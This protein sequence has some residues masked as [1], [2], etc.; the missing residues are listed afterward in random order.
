MEGK[1]KQA[2][3][4][5]FLKDLFY[6]CSGFDVLN[7]RADKEILKRTFLENDSMLIKL[8]KHETKSGDPIEFK[9]QK[10]DDGYYEYIGFKIC[11]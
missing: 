6:V 1:I 8:D 10:K 5:Q 11:N 9:Y 4:I 7:E 2:C 3:N